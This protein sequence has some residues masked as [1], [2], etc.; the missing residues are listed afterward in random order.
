[1]PVHSPFIQRE[2]FS[3][4]SDESALAKIIDEV[5]AG[6]ICSPINSP[7]A[8]SNWWPSREPS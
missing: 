4:I 2:S 5:I 3:Q 7:A 6:K 8:S 1:L